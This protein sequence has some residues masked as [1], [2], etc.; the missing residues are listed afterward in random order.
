MVLLPASQVQEPQLVVSSAVRA[1]QKSVVAP[2]RLQAVDDMAALQTSWEHW[3]GNQSI[4]TLKL[5]LQIGH[6][7]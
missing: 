7:G 2:G 1:E 5:I 4:L 6:Q 3:T